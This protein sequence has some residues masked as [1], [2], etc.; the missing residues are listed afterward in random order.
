MSKIIQRLVIFFAGL[1]ALIALV[2]F[3]PAY[4]HLCLN[5]AVIIFA[6]LGGLEFQNI[7]M[8]KKMY[9]PL[10]E[11]AVLGG[12]APCL[13]TA[14]ISFGFSRLG[15]CAVIMAAVSW[16]LLSGIFSAKDNRD[17]FIGKTAAGFS[18]LFYPGIFLSWIVAMS[19]LRESGFLIVGFF[20]M[21]FLNDSAAWAFGMLFGNGNRGLI[22]VSPNKSIAGF[23]GG[24]LASILIGIAGIHFYPQIPDARFFSFP[25]SG[26]VLGFCTGIAAT[27]GDLCESV[28]K[29]SAG[30]KDSGFLI[31]G[32]GGIL[33]SVDSAAMAAPVF[34]L[35]FRLLFVS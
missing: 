30:I 25:V 18:V 31:P 20:L 3:L 32:R 21:V 7:L 10:A 35:T 29:R 4:N 5:I 13:A 26:F 27:M 2:I 28:L 24:I 19:A 33:D 16:L 9:L 14:A 12:L 22:R 34:Y 23:A 6:V 17:A 15:C 8:Q 11:A 1:P